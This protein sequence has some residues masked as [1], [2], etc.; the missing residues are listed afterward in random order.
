MNST[1][2]ANNNS[3][4]PGFILSCLKRR[5][6]AFCAGVT[7]QGDVSPA[8]RQQGAENGQSP[9]AIIVTCSD[10]R[11]VPEHMFNAG[12]GELFVIRTAGNVV[13]AYELG[14]IE[15][16]VDHLGTRLII[17]L[18][19]NQCGAV[20][21]ALSGEAHGDVAA[22]IDTI[23]A[24]LPAHCDAREAERLNVLNTM[25]TI[26]ENKTLAAAEQAHELS[27]VGALYDLES[28]RVTFLNEA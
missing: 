17:V 7:H 18:G 6:E 3:P 9:L 20:A 2:P 21:A 1:S 23:A 15:Y 10:S 14:S 12:L 25:Q 8:L 4:D 26:R 28:G 16:A 5:N 22:I 24:I 13:G 27:I 19:H 11:V